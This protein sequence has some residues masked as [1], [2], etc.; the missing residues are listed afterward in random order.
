VPQIWRVSRRHCAHYKLNLLTYLLTYLLTN[1]LHT[2]LV[3]YSYSCVHHT[4][5]NLIS[6]MKDIYWLSEL[7]DSKSHFDIVNTIMTCNEIKQLMISTDKVVHKHHQMS[8]VKCNTVTIIVS[9]MRSWVT[10]RALY[11]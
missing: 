11:K 1:N 5:L 10:T 3:I 2:T 7:A 8:N 4:N 6:A 9:K